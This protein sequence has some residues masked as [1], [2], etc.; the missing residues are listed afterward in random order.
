METRP[1][2]YTINCTRWLEVTIDAKDTMV[3]AEGEKRRDLV[4]EDYLMDMFM[5]PQSDPTAF[6]ARQLTPFEESN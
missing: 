3:F 5:R 2:T 1:H 6:I 4:L